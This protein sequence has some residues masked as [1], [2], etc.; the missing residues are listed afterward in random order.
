[1]DVHRCTNFIHFHF[2]DL[3]WHFPIGIGTKVV[4]LGGVEI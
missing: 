3:H 1:M 4:G 2:A